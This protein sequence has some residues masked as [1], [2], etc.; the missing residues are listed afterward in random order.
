MFYLLDTMPVFH[1]ERFYNAILP[2]FYFDITENYTYHHDNTHNRVFYIVKLGFTWEYMFFGGF[3]LLNIDRGYT[4][5]Q[6]H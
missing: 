6:P 5:E 1:V 4:L 2:I 3:L